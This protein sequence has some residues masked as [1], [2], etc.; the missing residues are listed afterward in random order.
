MSRKSQMCNKRRAEW[1]F[2]SLE[3]VC[4]PCCKSGNHWM[5]P[6]H[7]SS[8]KRVNEAFTNLVDWSTELHGN[9][10]SHCL[11]HFCRGQIHHSSQWKKA[12]DAPQDWV[13]SNL[14][15]LVWK[16]P[17]NGNLKKDWSQRTAIGNV[18]SAGQGL[19]GGRRACYDPGCSRSFQQAHVLQDYRWA[20]RTYSIPPG[21]R[22]WN[23][24]IGYC[25]RS[26]DRTH[27]L[28]FIRPT[29]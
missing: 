24:L 25:T 26:G 7:S 13:N 9:F 29:L 11:H 8:S 2:Q 10:L 20:N 21:I 27:D 1:S 14:L 17:W 23:V 22:T 18:F 5:C 15:G 3:A 12:L 6:H 16:V 4:P 28:G 19:R